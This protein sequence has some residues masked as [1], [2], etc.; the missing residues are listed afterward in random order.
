MGPEGTEPEAGLPQNKCSLL[1]IPALLDLLLLLTRPWGLPCF[2][3]SLVC[4]LFCEMDTESLVKAVLWEG[5]ALTSLPVWAL[6][7]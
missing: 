2:S 6:T 4:W 7:S 5:L 1:S 3:F